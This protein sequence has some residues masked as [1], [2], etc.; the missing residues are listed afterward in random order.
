MVTC[1]GCEDLED[2]PK[3]FREELRREDLER[4]KEDLDGMILMVMIDCEEVHEDEEE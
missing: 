4:I 3:R 1:G 2:D